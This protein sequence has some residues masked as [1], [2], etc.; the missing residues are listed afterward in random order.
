MADVVRKIDANVPYS[1]GFAVTPDDDADNCLFSNQ[2][3]RALYLTR[4]AGVMLS[5]PTFCHIGSII[6]DGN[7]DEGTNAH[8]AVILDDNAFDNMIDSV[9][10]NNWTHAGANG[11]ALNIHGSRNIIG[12]IRAEGVDSWDLRFESTANDNSIINAVLGGGGTGTN[13]DGGTDN[14][15]GAIS[16]EAPGNGAYVLLT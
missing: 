7:V 10:V 8:P 15:I 3:C 12:N 11:Q 9:I 16:I 4:A 6:V 5:A 13:S 1:E 14:R 2:P